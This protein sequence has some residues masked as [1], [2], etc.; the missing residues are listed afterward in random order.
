MYA[1]DLGVALQLTNIVRDIPEDLARGRLY[2]PLDDLAAC[3]CT[4][5]DIAGGVLTPPVKALIAFECDRARTF[6]RRAVEAR[7]DEDRGRLVAAEIM[8]AVYFETLRRIERHGYDVF[9][10]RARPPR[11][12]QAAIAHQAMVMAV[13]TEAVVVVGAGFAGLSAAVRLAAAG[14][15]VVV[16]EA[17]A[18]LGGRATAFEDRETGELVDNGQHV[19]LGC[20]ADTFA[21]LQAI[22]AADA[23]RLQAGLGVT[24]IDRAG[25]RTRL[26]CPSLPPPLH[27]LA[28]VMEW[29]ALG[30]RDRLAVLRLAPAIRLARRAIDPNAGVIAA[31]AAETV[32]RWLER[33]GQTPRLIEMLW[34]PL[35]LAALNQPPDRAAAPVFARVLAEMFG[36]APR[37]AAIGWPTRPLHLMYAEPARSWLE[38]H[39]AEVHTGVAARVILADG[40]VD[41]VEAAGE[42]WRPGAVIVAVPWFALGEVLAGETAPM[43]PVLGRAA[44]MES[45]PI[46]T[47]NLWFD[48]AV[49]DEPFVGLP[50]RPV[51]WVFDKRSVLGASASH[52]SVVASG[53]AELAAL[54][55]DRLIR[56]AHGELLDAI[57]AVR[58][59]ALT[60]ATVIREPRATFS[61]APGQPARPPAET[62]VDGLVL[63][64]DW[65][66]T[67]LPATI[68]SAVRS[69]HRAAEIVLTTGARREG[70]DHGK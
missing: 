47:V 29:E 3:G 70:N 61:L 65:I 2:L 31:S 35:A 27:L 25:R 23:V 43:A 34:H 24:M 4:P 46:V 9:T 57:P 36:S 11:A 20:Y 40:A 49:M 8:R 13:L 54:S 44:R 16:L 32:E 45:S 1:L 18:R 63:A 48:R 62:P 51:Q 19:L 64:G 7:P 69:G 66:D 67:G 33:N 28:G 50:G 52:L 60:R 15:R 26:S 53:A 6:Y 56:V 41:A 37:A 12:V 38:R 14:R 10:A 21:F 30:W 55:N 22:G 17:R 59:A 42:R 58:P 39:D 5:E 68:E